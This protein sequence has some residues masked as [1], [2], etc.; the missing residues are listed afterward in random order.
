MVGTLTGLAEFEAD[1]K[2]SRFLARAMPIEDEDAAIAFIRSVSNPDATHNCWAW[3]I[4]Q[5]YRSEDDGEPGGTAGRPSLQ[6]IE[7]QDLDRVVVVV[8]RWFGGIKLGAGGLVRAYGGTAAECLRTADRI[9][10]IPRQRLKFHCLF[11]DHARLRARLSHA[12][13]EIVEEQFGASGV[14]MEIMV[15]ET[16]CDMIRTQIVDMTRGHALPEII[17]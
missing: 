6:V 17:D 14:D 1:I 9:E 8:T 11:T 5:R 4:G 10:L 2:K 12:G 16:G 15:A 13:V 3:K 7:G